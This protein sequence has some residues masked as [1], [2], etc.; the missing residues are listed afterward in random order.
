M[1]WFLPRKVQLL[2]SGLIRHVNAALRAYRCFCAASL[3]VVKSGIAAY[4]AAH[5]M[6]FFD[7]ASVAT[8]MQFI[9]KQV[10]VPDA[11]H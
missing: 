3:S 5:L 6:P 11:P 2:A 1:V 8:A 4:F 7:A 9:L 10:G